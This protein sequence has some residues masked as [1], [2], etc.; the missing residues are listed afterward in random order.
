ME[1][2]DRVYLVLDELHRMKGYIN[3]NDLNFIV[4]AKDIATLKAIKDLYIYSV[5]LID[6]IDKALDQIEG[7]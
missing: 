4:E 3:V 2:K 7:E 6:Y 1:Y 5:D